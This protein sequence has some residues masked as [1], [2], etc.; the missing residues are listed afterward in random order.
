MTLYSCWSSKCNATDESTPPDRSMA[1]VGLRCVIVV[2]ILFSIIGGKGRCTSPL[3]VVTTEL[4]PSS[5]AEDVAFLS[6]INDLICRCITRTIDA[7]PSFRP[8]LS[9]DEN[10]SSVVSISGFR[11]KI[12]STVIMLPSLVI[13]VVVATAVLLLAALPSSASNMDCPLLNMSE[14]IASSPRLSKASA[15]PDRCTLYFVI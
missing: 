14:S 11:F 8:R 4:L 9:I 5:S 12:C 7:T 2:T 15:V 1:T 13:S 6:C 3:F 10:P